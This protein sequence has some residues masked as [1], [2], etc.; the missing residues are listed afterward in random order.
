MC[1][2]LRQPG[3]QKRYLKRLGLRFEVKPNGRPLVS[4]SGVQG[5]LDGFTAPMPG[6]SAAAPNVDALKSL[7]NKRKG[8]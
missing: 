4:R 8:I 3:A 7:F 2:P 1:S 6:T 5:L